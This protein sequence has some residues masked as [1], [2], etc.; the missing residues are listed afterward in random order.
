MALNIK[1]VVLIQVNLV[2]ITIIIIAIIII[3]NLTYMLI[4]SIEDH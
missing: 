1:L 2:I 4:A 3:M